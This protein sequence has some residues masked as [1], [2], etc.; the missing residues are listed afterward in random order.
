[1]KNICSKKFGH[2]LNCAFGKR[3]AGSFVLIFTLMFNVLPLVGNA[4]EEDRSAEIDQKLEL[5]YGRVV[6][7]QKALDGLANGIRSTNNKASENAFAIGTQSDLMA[8]TR[9]MMDGYQEVLNTI[10]ADLASNKEMLSGLMQE[11]EDL[12]QE[13]QS[14]LGQIKTAYAVAIGSAVITLILALVLARSVVSKN[15]LN[16]YSLVQDAMKTQQ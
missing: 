8:E 6:K 14:S 1:M 7:N 12:R 11:Q 10:Q 16:W 9:Q 13:I 15:K 4:Q 3:C 5:L 2:L